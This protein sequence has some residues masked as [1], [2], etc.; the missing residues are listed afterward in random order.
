MILFVVFV[1]CWALFWLPKEDF[2]IYSDYL[3]FLTSAV[4]IF[5]AGAFGIDYAAKAGLIG[6]G[7]SQAPHVPLGGRT[8]QQSQTLPAD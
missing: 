7:R 2:K 1:N 4:V 6:G 5:A 8:R 3:Q